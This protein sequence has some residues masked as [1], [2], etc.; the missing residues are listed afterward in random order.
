MTTTP[1]P[2]PLHDESRRTWWVFL[3]LAVVVATA[4]RLAYPSGI[5]VEH[6]DEGVYASNLWCPDTLVPGNYSY[7][8][9]HLYAPPLLPAS[10]ET[11]QLLLGTSGLATIVP[12][13]LAG[14]VLIVVLGAMVRDWL[15]EP[16]ARVVVVLAVSSDVHILFS[17]TALTDVSWITWLVIATGLAHR[18][19]VGGRFPVLAAAGIA[20]GLGWWT[21]YTGWLPLA[22][23]AAGIAATV[24]LVPAT[25]QRCRTWL[26]RLCLIIAVTAATIAPLLW[27]L[28]ETGGY[29]PVARNH[30]RFLVGISGWPASAIEQARN[31]MQLESLLTV[32]GLLLASWLAS[33]PVGR[34]TWNAIVPRLLL[35]LLLAGFAAVASFTLIVIPLAIFALVDGFREIRR[36]TAKSLSGDDRH[37]AWGM[38]AAWWIAMTVTIPLYYPYPRLSLPWLVAGWILVGRGIVTLTT[39]ADVANRSGRQSLAVAGLGLLLLI[40]A[41]PAGLLPR[42]IPAWQSRTAIADLAD[43]LIDRVTTAHPEGLVVV[44]V[45]GEPAL[46]YQLSVRGPQRLLLQPA[47]GLAVIGPDQPVPEAPVFLVVGPH[48]IESD[49][50]RQQDWSAFTQVDGFKIRPGLQVRLNQPSDRREQAMP[51]RLLRWHP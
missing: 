39:A 5:A 3:A 37:L 21:K 7:P 28:G 40:I 8:D 12:S 51:F 13:L 50:A 11:S 36:R 15:G 43:Q 48:V 19:L 17:R 25:R 30:A 38:L 47:G 31:L 20:T 44:R 10:I 2:G 23:T 16:T 34:F 32:L 45:W 42:A 22:V 24:V 4:L 1:D 14:V 27:S 46:F 29:G 33:G 26:L 6:F 35:P 9:R 49:Q 18:G 41:V